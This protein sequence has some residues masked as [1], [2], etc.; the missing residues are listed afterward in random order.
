ME[1]IKVSLKLIKINMNLKNLSHI[2]FSKIIDIYYGIGL[3]TFVGFTDTV[4]RFR[5]RLETVYFSARN[6]TK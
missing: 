2:V 6:V 1:S 3:K 4:V 5:S